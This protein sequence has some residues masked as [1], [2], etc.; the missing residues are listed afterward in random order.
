MNGEKRTADRAFTVGVPASATEPD[1]AG[2]L[3][4]IRR[5]ADAAGGTYEIIVAVNGGDE[6]AALA[7][8]R[9]FAAT[10]GVPL[11]EP[12]G[13]CPPPERSPALAPGAEPAVAPFDGAAPRLAAGAVVRVLRVRE[14]SKVAAWNAIRA[15]A[16][17]PIIVFTDADVRLAPAAI[18]LLLARLAAAPALVAAA[19]REVAALRPEDGLVARL[20]A[21]PYRFDFG[22]LPGRLYALR[23]AALDE[24]MPPHVLAEDAYLSVWLGR[25]R[26][27]KVQSALVY[28]RPPATWREYVDQRVRN[29][30]GKRQLA[31]DFPHLLRAHGFG[32]TPWRAF[33]RDL[34]PREY[35]LV[36]LSLAVRVYARAA[37]RRHHR[38]KGFGRGWATLPSTKAWD[39]GGEPITETRAAS[40]GVPGAEAASRAHGS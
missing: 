5:S 20:A 13:A 15:A 29:E 26:F 1:L 14:H 2:T 3:E 40:P 33:V 10:A 11:V 34:R 30:L 7:G 39:G 23:A 4:S 32:V 8:V 24:A 19:G 16:R 22:N 28:L 18:A 9:A 38:R 21:L 37:A 6:P 35:V 31:A 36:A 12:D 27:T 25:A 17:A